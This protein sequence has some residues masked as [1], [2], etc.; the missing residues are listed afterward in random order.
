VTEARSTEVILLDALQETANQSVTYLTLRELGTRWKLCRS[1][2][3]YDTVH[4]EHFPN[5][6]SLGRCLRYEEARVREW[7]KWP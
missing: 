1:S 6:L 3:V 4:L 2:S 7:E 5:P